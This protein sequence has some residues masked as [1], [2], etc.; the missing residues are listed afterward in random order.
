MITKE[1]YVKIWKWAGFSPRETH[2]VTPD[3]NAFFGW[4]E[5][6]LP[7]FTLQR[8]GKGCYLGAADVYDENA[9]CVKE[10]REN[11]ATAQEACYLAALKFIEG[12]TEGIG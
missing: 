9:L 3:L 10:I 1:Q 12:Q 8:F 11:G 4:V 2:L 7:E 6:K 5:P